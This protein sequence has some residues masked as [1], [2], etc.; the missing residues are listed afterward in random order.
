MQGLNRVRAQDRAD[1]RNLVTTATFYWGHATDDD[2]DD[3]GLRR[4]NIE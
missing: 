1:W 4:V 3:V 2:D